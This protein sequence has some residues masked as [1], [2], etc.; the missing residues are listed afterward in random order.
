[1]VGKFLIF[2]PKAKKGA[3]KNRRNSLPKNTFVKISDSTTPMD[4]L[5]GVSPSEFF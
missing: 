1:M 4:I 2:L 5:R 3:K